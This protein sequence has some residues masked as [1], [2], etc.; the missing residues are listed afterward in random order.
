MFNENPLVEG[1]D[2][3]ELKMKKVSYF[4][5]AIS[6]KS[7]YF[8]KASGGT[9]HTLSIGTLKKMYLAES[10]LEIQGLDTYYSPLL[11]NY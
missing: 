3:I 8:R 9:G 4:I 10:V 7:I 1:L 6:N 2:E 5:T 11:L